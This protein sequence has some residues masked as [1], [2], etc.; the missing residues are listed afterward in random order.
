M[1]GK[2]IPREIPLRIKHDIK[3]F[4][5]DFSTAQSK[6]HDLLFAAGD[7]GEV[8]LPK[9]PR[10][11]PHL[12]PLHGNPEE[13]DLIKIHIR[14]GKLTFLHYDN[15]KNQRPVLQTRINTHVRPGRNL[16]SQTPAP[17]SREARKQRST[18]RQAFVEHLLV[19]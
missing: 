10:R 15:F 14:S 9:L 7:P 6:A 3:A 19:A 1:S 17:S 5:K 13:A 4:F 11:P 18:R 8:L 12:R 2:R 16:R